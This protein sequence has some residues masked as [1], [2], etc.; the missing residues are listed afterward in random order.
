MPYAIAHPVAVIPLARA[1]GRHAVPSALAIGS[2]IPDAWYFFP[3]VER[4]FSHDASGLVVFC[5]PW[6]L[7]A[8]LLFHLLLKEPLLHLLPRGLASRARAF[9]VPGLPKVSPLA[10][11]ACVA[12]GAATHLAWDAFTHEGPFSRSIPF[13]A[14]DVL[15]VL[16]HASTLLGSA[17]LG[18]W[19]WRKLRA[20]S[21]VAAPVLSPL[22]QAIVLVALAAVSMAGFTLAWPS[23]ELMDFRRALRIAAGSTGTALAAALVVYGLLFHALRRTQQR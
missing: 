3:G 14:E 8:Y 18:L 10:V 13:L 21:P 4:P 22:I 16:Q 17:V 5:L 7:L 15:R 2:V 20:V 23:T 19:V 1:L 6:G 12:L 11:V 9:A